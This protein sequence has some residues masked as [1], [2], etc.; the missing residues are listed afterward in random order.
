MPMSVT[1][2]T[3]PRGGCWDGVAAR[4]S[5]RYI[6]RMSVVAA[7][8]EAGPGQQSRSQRA[9]RWRAL[10]AVLLIVALLGAGAAAWRWQRGLSLFDPPGAELGGHL[11]L[12]QTEYIIVVDGSKSMPS[13]I[14]VRSVTPR[15][16]SNTAHA[17]VRVVQCVQNGRTVVL[18]ATKHLN[19]CSGLHPFVPGPVRFSEGLHTAIFVVEV[20]AYSSGRLRIHGVDVQYRRGLRTGQQTT[21][22]DIDYRSR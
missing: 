20:R 22:F 17:S 5:A 11:L 7:S 15:I 6:R 13:T 10:A 1:R 2:A 14:D 9:R 21:G 8:P 3:M 4:S 18:G 12:G 16:I 19:F